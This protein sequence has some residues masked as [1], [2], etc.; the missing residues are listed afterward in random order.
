MKVSRGPAWRENGV[1]AAALGPLGAG[2]GRAG[3]KVVP[4]DSLVGG[5]GDV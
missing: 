5:L 3:V 1:P 2:C 4:R